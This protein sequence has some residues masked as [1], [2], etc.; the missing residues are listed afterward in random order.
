MANP[1]GSILLLCVMNFLLF[2]DIV[3]DDIMTILDQRV[4]ISLFEIKETSLFM[5]QDP[6]IALFKKIF[7][8]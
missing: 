5:V 7:F 1:R 6:P 3:T 2:L 4:D 8:I